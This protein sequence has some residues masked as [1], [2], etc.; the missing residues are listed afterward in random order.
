MPSP[1]SRPVAAALGLVP[2]VLGGVRRLPGK[3]VQLPVFAV[4]HALT[5]IGAARQ[6]YDDLAERGERLIARLRGTS[7]DEIE[8]R[9]EDALQGTPL[10][11]PYDRVEDALEDAGEAVT[12]IT[13]SATTRARKATGTATRT[14]GNGLS[15]A[16]GAVE[17]AAQGVAGT[18]DG[19]GTADQAADKMGAAA[20]TGT[21][22]TPA[23]ASKPKPKRA[24]DPEAAAKAVAEAERHVAEAA[25]RAEQAAAE[26]AEKAAAAGVDP[27]Q[28]ERARK[29]PAQAAKGKATPKATQPDDTRVDTA[30]SPE[31]VQA[32]EQVSS[33]VGGVVLEH[34]QLPLPDYDHLTLGSLRG[35]MRSL[36][37]PQLIQIRD[38]EKAHAD[39]LPIITMLDN[40]IAKLANDPT[41]P[42]SGSSPAEAADAPDKPTASRTGSPVNPTTG[43]PKQ[44]PTSQ[45]D[46]TNP[47]QPRGSGSGSTNPNNPN[48]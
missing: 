8:D 7:F 41:A 16:A 29:N 21:A 5:G 28:V 19:A 14:V 38:Y 4:S 2:T 32:V 12:S 33:R 40:R 36:D 47:G 39:R 23:K 46:P 18:S 1:V 6:G 45:G 48:S 43:G 27:A 20:D 42:L 31:V 44:N 17:D 30:A 22:K 11:G 9:V 25:Q 34:D 10:A 37:L 13:R 3:A 26:A 15:S 35:R 24:V